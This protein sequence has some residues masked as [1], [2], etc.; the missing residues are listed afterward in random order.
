M[1]IKQHS[2]RLRTARQRMDS[3]Q[4]R[5]ADAPEQRSRLWPEAV[6]E[7]AA[8]LEERQAIYA[9]LEEQNEQLNEANEKCMAERQRYQE[10]FEFAPD[11]YLV[12]N[13]T[14][15]IQEANLAAA[16][17]LQVP[18]G[19]L[20]GS[21]LFRFVVRG[22]HRIFEEHLLRLK[23]EPV[24]GGLKLRLESHR[25]PSFP[26][27]LTV[28]AI[29]QPQGQLIGLRWQLREITERPEPPEA[30]RQA[31]EESERGVRQRIAEMEG[32][33]RSF[34]EVCYHV[35]HDLRAPLRAIQG[36]TTLLLREN[37][38]CLDITG[39]DY[40]RKVIHAAS[41]MD[42][43]IRDLVAYG[44]LSQMELHCRSVDLNLKMDQLLHLLDDEIR[45]NSADV[46]VARPLPGV[47]ADPE[48]VGL[49][50]L[51][52]LS[53]ALKFVA[54]NT[55]PRIQVRGETSGGMVRLSLQDNGLGIAPEHHERIFGI[56]ERLQEAHFG[57]G[58]GLAMVRQGIQRLGGTVGLE[59]SP[60][61][62]SRFWLELP[63]AKE[64][65]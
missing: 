10:L 28:G 60:G 37:A 34:E 59:S 26:A 52:L 6:A 39:R 27:A 1:D 13:P 21:P 56:F 42:V 23:T 19:L 17:L 35:T 62:G 57:T 18:Q 20:V 29:R 46:Q 32:I 50:I 24:G 38:A 11:G 22:D 36:F 47:W 54:P 3:L 14:G 65:A 63:Q 51:H 45:A 31:L 53:N 48:V 61:V 33:L 9:A 7:L 49:A 15:T 30:L 12:T 5:G 43:L 55:S 41:R 44:H 64:G 25:R 16:T 2:N 40:G 8:S 4:R 58:I